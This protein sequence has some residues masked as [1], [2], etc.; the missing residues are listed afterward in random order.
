[1]EVEA[2]LLAATLAIYLPEVDRPLGCGLSSKLHVV[3]PHKIDIAAMLGVNPSRLK[4]VKLP[5][6]CSTAE[7]K[8]GD[9]VCL[10][11]CGTLRDISCLVSL[12]KMQELDIFRCRGWH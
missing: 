1:V 9:I 7:G 5:D 12:V 11:G 10:A 2:G 3:T 6:T 4:D 8:A